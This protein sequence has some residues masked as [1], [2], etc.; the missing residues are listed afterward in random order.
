MNVFNLNGTIPGILVIS[1]LCLIVLVI[2]VTVIACLATHGMF[3][4]CCAQ[5]RE[6]NKRTQPGVELEGNREDEEPDRLALPETVEGEPNDMPMSTTGQKVQPMGYPKQGYV[7]DD[8]PSE[9]RVDLDETP[10]FEAPV[11]GPDGQI[12]QPPQEPAVTVDPKFKEELLAAINDTKLEIVCCFIYVFITQMF[13][14]FFPFL[15]LFFI[16]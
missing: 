4:L 7:Q 1:V 13:I 16:T 6:A 10:E 9:G 15:L 11:L 12:I 8:E 3:G 2:I 14:F 5:C